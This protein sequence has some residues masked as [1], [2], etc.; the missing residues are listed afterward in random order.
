ME[1]TVRFELTASCLQNSCS[2]T[3]L[4]RPGQSSIEIL[5]AALRS[6]GGEVELALSGHLVEE[7]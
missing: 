4:R 6:V 2:T 5:A 7:D 1:P 3:E